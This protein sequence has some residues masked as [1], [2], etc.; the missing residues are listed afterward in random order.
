M[1]I[2]SKFFKENSSF[3]KFGGI[4]SEL[5]REEIVEITWK[6]FNNSTSSGVELLKDSQLYSQSPNWGY[7]L[8]RL[9]RESTF[10]HIGFNNVEICQQILND[11]I[12]W[13][14]KT[15]LKAQKETSYITEE[16]NLYKKEENQNRLSSFDL[17]ETL[18]QLMN[19]YPN[20]K[21]TWA[22][23][24]Q[25]LTL[26]KKQKKKS[27]TNEKHLDSEKNALYQKI[28]SDWSK[29]LNSKRLHAQKKIMSE[30]FNRFIPILN[31]K[32]EKLL[33][34]YQ[35]LS[36]F[37]GFFGKFWDLSQGDWQSFDWNELERY[38]KILEQEK[39]IQELA[40]LLGKYKTQSLEY[41]EEVLQ[42]T[43]LKQEWQVDFT[44]KSEIVGVCFSDDLSNLLPS[45][46]ALLSDPLTETIFAKKFVD[47]KLLT[48]HYSGQSLEVKE[49]QIPEIKQKAKEDK[50][51]P[52][53]VCVDTS[54][55]MFGEPERIA[56]TIVFALLSIAIREKR[57]CYLIS[58]ST[59]IE[60]LDLSDMENSIPKLIQFLSMGFCGGTDANF[61]FLE[62]LKMLKTENYRKADVLMVSDFVM[63]SLPDKV[64][65]QIQDERE[66]KST[67]FHSLAITSDKNSYPIMQIF[68]NFWIYDR[69]SPNALAGTVKKIRDL[70]T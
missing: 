3:I 53:I 16:N 1:S 44:T 49:E 51:G 27:K 15:H 21:K 11:T 6:H 32:Y 36:P 37:F 47:K 12:P 28:L 58:F 54:G 68:D 61:A 24:S 18:E 50:K 13:I 45:E 62:A 70:Y 7:I 69:Y 23:Y 64:V 5:E 25:K 66:N 39:D 38:A 9:F 33:K 65:Q 14:A 26:L 40:E 2:P 17:D 29:N 59:Q 10:R 20:E 55:S 30:E 43:I 19:L 56:K 57:R 34:L 35:N 8:S 48:W 63:P 46:T 52:I 41:E 31:A 60:T 67:R 42:K 4:I 22:F